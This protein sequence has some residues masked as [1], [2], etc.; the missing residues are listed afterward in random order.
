MI[1]FFSYEITKDDD[2]SLVMS[3]ADTLENCKEKAEHDA[4]YYITECGYF[5]LKIHIEEVCKTCLNKGTIRRYQKRNKFIFKVVKCPE[6]NGKIPEFK[7]D[8]TVS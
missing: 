2:K 8:Y 3:G 4:Q 5:P 7:T 6:C 1:T